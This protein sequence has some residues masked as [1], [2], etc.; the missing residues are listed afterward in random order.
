[1]LASNLWVE[2]GLVNGSMGT[3]TAICYKSGQAPPSLPVSIMI[4][5]DSYSGPTY[6]D[7]TVPITPVRRSWSM[8]GVQCSRLQLPLKLAW[9]VTIHKAQGLTL[10]KVVIDVG[11]KEFSSGLTFVACSRVRHLFHP[12]FPFQRLANLSRS[13]RLQERLREDSRL[14]QLETTTLQNLQSTNPPS[15][16]PSSSSS[17]VVPSSNCSTPSVS[18][19]LHSQS[20]LF[21]PSHFASPSRL[22]TP[23]P[24]PPSSVYSRT[25]SPLAFSATPSPP[26]SCMHSL[27][28]SP[29]SSS[30]CT[31]SPPSS[32]MCSP[33]SSTQSSP[34]HS[35]TSPPPF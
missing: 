6:P 30:V 21:S 22:Y 2:A 8:S 23:T 32:C 12:P 9:A 19:P 25:P 29:P 33:T 26:S 24:S 28:P 15:P 5:F 4:H 18:T 34:Q 10:D 35:P 17:V 1:M 3:V 20:P 14:Q 31:P 16:Q 11:K 27:T 13:Q 7:G